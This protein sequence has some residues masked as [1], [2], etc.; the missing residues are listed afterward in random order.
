MIVV[1]NEKPF[2]VLSIDGGGM[3]GL[4]TASLLATLAN[5]FNKRE[6]DI[7]MGFDLIV[8]TSTGSILAGGLIAGI[9]I[10][11]IIDLYYKIGPE[12]FTDPAPRQSNF[13]LIK[14][15]W[16]NRNKSANSNKRLREALNDIFRDETLADVYTRRS[17]GLC[18]PTVDM[19]THNAQIFK[20]PHRADR[21][22]DDKRKLSE[23]IL[24]SSAAPIVLPL[25]K[26]SN[27]HIKASQSYFADG[28][29]WAN[30]PVLVA[31]I[32]AL[33]IS[34]NNQSIEIISIGSCSP[35]SGSVIE[36]A[37]KMG[38][39]AWKA[40][41]NILD[42]SMEAQ[43]SGNQFIAKHLAR[44]ISKLG[45]KIDVVRLDHSLPSAK[46]V[47][48]LALDCASEN[49]R[50]ILMERGSKDALHIYGKAT[51]SDGEYTKLS[52][53]FHSMPAINEVKK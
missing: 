3:R 5:Q 34:K 51:S 46:Q 52:P 29:L 18:V 14:W 27:P 47:D 37:E 26:I 23:I 11:T 22:A 36:T 12:I 15:I 44:L 49:A 8:G 1:Q 30:N 9:P 35:P 20:T 2:R 7:G 45:K 21:T 28:G 50:Q 41:I 24:A 53:L 32:E 38:I 4:Y 48:F 10:S 17:I 39:I 31:M 33:D 42:L 25:A 16:R 6:C 43:A 13:K 19:T 40:G